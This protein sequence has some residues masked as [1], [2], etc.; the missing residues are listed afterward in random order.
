[1]R[2]LIVWAPEGS[3]DAVRH[4]AGR[5]DATG[6]VTLTGQGDDGPVDIVLLHVPNRRV[7]AVIADLSRVDGLHVSMLPQGAFALAPPSAQAP[8]QVTDVTL[9]SPLEIFLGGLQSIGSWR[10]FLGY[11]LAGGIVAWIGLYTNSVFLLVAAMLIAPF[12]GPA[13]NTAVAT[14][15]GD[16]HLL[17]R[18]VARYAA[19]LAV[20]I[21]TATLMSL[22]FGQRIATE[23]MVQTASISTTAVLLPLVAGFAGAV[24]LIQSERSSLV[25][26][27][28]VGI[29]VAA[30]LAP[31]AGLVGM[32]AVLGEW[33]MVK[34]GVFLLALQLAG[35]NLS[36]TL[37]FR[38]A[39][40]RPE[41]TLY[42]RGRGRT[43]KVSL[44]A[45]LLAIAG[46]LWWQL[47]DVPELQRGSL[48]QR[49]AAA[50]QEVVN[51]SG[52]A[53]LVEANVRF[54]RADI[55]GQNTLLAEIYVQPAAGESGPEIE[56]QT[57]ARIGREIRRRFPS[58][59]PL[60]SVTALQ[61]P[62]P[63]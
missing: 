12:A 62:E 39:G 2:R 59:T 9:R 15:R 31:P 55:P 50:V 35:I 63:D 46:L 36:G 42:P 14:A 53:R 33:D 5:H 60:I 34:G 19:A 54:T 4:T 17:G 20:A 56:R 45:T 52:N 61:P 24:S 21:A 25:S 6:L 1:M 18:S 43:Q 10:G 22:I 8:D 30:A 23:Q 32:A 49:A 28:A 51:T 48:Q 47:G 37:V 11:A 41:G 27:A 38:I 13:M 26:G 58:V 40:L 3:A 16:L 29:L 7:G 57:S 44:A